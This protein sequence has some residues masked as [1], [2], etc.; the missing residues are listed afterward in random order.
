[1]ESSWSWMAWQDP[2]DARRYRQSHP[3]VPA[4]VAP[5]ELETAV[6][7]LQQRGWRFFGLVVEEGA[8]EPSAW[9]LT[10]VWCARHTPWLL[11]EVASRQ[12]AVPSVS[13]TVF[14]A[15]WPEREAEDLF[16]LHFTGHPQLGDFVLHDEDWGEDLSPMRRDFHQRRQHSQGVGESYRPPRILEAAGGFLMPVGPVFS[17][18]QESIRFLLETVGEEIVHAHVRLFY[19][20]RGIEQ[21]MQ[22]RRPEDALLLAE[23]V[24]GPQAFAHALA[25]AQ[26]VET[27]S[28]VPVPVRARA[29]RTVLAEM[30]RIRMHVRALAG[31]VESTGLAVPTNL[32]DAVEER[33]LQLSAAYLGHRYLF[34]VAAIGGLALD[35]PDEAV[36]ALA[37]QLQSEIKQVVEV[38]GR[39]SF[40]NSFLDRLEMVGRLSREEAG[41]SG[42]VGPIARA[43]AVVNDLRDWQPYAYYED[44]PP[45]LVTESEGDGYARFRVFRREIEVAADLIERISRDMPTGP[46][47]VEAR[48]AGGTGMGAVE[49]PSGAL[50]YWLRVNDQGRLA[51]CHIMTPALMNWHALPAAVQAF[52]FQDFPIILATFG[53]SVADADR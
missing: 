5:A 35:L 38:C 51:R 7:A 23:R 27:L 8:E 46:V 6:Q 3:V 24:N 42:A 37:Q 18:P 43:S 13:A 1:M 2:L 29:L 33:L 47:R 12:D 53:L 9:Q 19:K 48:P 20:Y 44:M 11:L 36:R 41:S 21:L 49:A 32:L 45:P 22:G 34:G 52:A 39:L 28:P 26:A 14:A 40:D 31:I 15:D 10:Y 4:S 17:G 50:V 16:G 30:E 25:F